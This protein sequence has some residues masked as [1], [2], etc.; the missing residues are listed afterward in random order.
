MIVNKSV[1]P[2]L[3]IIPAR[4][5]S[6]GLPRK[7]VLPFMGHP[8]I[9]HSIMLAQMCPEIDQL[10]VS[11]DSDEIAIVAHKY[12]ADVIARPVELAQD[13]TPM[14]PVLQHALNAVEQLDDRQ[15][16]SLMLIDPTSPSRLPE[17]VAGFAKCLANNPEADGVVCVSQPEFSP[18]WHCVIEK[19]GWMADLIPGAD[20]FTRRQDL[21]TTY[22]INGLLYLWRRSHVLGASNW[23]QGRLLKY[24]VPEHRTIHIDDVY[25]M[26]KAELLVKNGL[27]EFP[28]LGVSS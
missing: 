14:W 18:F 7:N 12:G 6:K 22:R 24:E 10:V 5:G 23:R 15:Y 11:T 26:R 2:L 9:A 25:E 20:S 8:L 17:D 13:I 28:W 19:D 16:G 1:H 27:I 3:A 21:P 4:G